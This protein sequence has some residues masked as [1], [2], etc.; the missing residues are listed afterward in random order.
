[1]TL[2]EAPLTEIPGVGP[3][4]AEKL[5]LLGLRQIGDCLWHL[6]SRYE[7]RSR[8]VP[9]GALRPEK[10]E[11]RALIRGSVIHSVWI[12]RPKPR[13]KVTITDGTGTCLLHFFHVARGQGRWTLGQELLCF[14]PLTLKRD[15]W[16]MGQPECVTLTV[17]QA[18]PVPDTW[19]PIYP[20]R[21]GV[22]QALLRKV[23]AWALA[24]LGSEILELLPEAIAGLLPC[25]LSEA[26]AWIHAPPL[27]V[28]VQQLAERSHPAYE[29]LISEELL[30]HQWVLQG[31]R[32]RRQ[33]QQAPAIPLEALGQA[34]SHLL[35]Q[36]SFQ[37]TQAQLRVYQELVEDLQGAHPMNRLLQGD[38]G[39]GKTI[40][41]A[42]AML[43]VAFGGY[44]SALMVP[45][46]V[47]AEQQAE[48]FQAWCA[49]TGLKV[50]LLSAQKQGKIRKQCLAEIASGEVH[51]IIGT[52]ALFQ[53]AVQFKSLGFIV[54][55]EQHRFGVHQRWTLGQK[56]QAQIP[57]QLMMTAT[58]IP[59][60]LAM[61]L[62]GDL[63]VS[64]LDEKPPGRKAIQTVILPGE[65]RASVI[66]RL[67]PWLAQGRQ[68][69]WIC[70]LIEESEKLQ[71][72]NVE[73]T[74]ALL[75]RALPGYRI[76]Q[77][78]GRLSSDQKKAVMQ[79]FGAGREAVLVAT[80]VIEVGV[81]VPNAALMVI[82][83]AE[84]LGLSQLHQLRGRVG[85]GVEDSVCLL[86]YQSPLS[87]L[88]KQRLQVLRDSEDGFYIAEKDFELRGAGEWLGTRQTGLASYK[89]ADLSKDT[90]YLQRARQWV[91]VLRLSPEAEAALLQRWFNHK[92]QYQG[93]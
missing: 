3:K 15:Q 13:Q 46:E 28:S 38:V 37:L 65:R 4:I 74:Q 32:Q 14:G 52:H 22:S 36:I 44:Q 8:V 76:A 55:D 16:H 23:I 67:R 2:F 75:A 25:T 81:D 35:N 20:T 78:H 83:N 41:A 79:S 84:R 45:T 72:E 85:R 40:V 48:R 39:S 77:I 61:T 12:S 89:V 92:P 64:I 11:G 88:A 17:G 30:I 5:A 27:S 6:P 70:P 1:M 71:C 43:G 47:L 58:P 24:Q 91:E 34:K 31:R 90:A 82:D 57:H 51:L 42:L 59:R 53:E 33:A 54:I 18:L 69:Y 63:S 73:E 86:L 93:V 68:C 66:E 10:I 50:V 9:I 7:D 56:G 26:L 49:G 62:Y 87:L 19:Q 29:R 21:E 80:T 60:T